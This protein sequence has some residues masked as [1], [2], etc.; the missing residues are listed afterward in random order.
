M[1]LNKSFKGA[2]FVMLIFLCTLFLF[3]STASAARLIVSPTTGAFEVG[4]TFSI[5]IFLDTEGESINAFDVKLNF[6]SGKLQLISPS[7]GKSIVEIWT[8]PPQYNNRAGTVRLQ[9]GIPNGITA[10]RGLITELTFRVKQVGSAVLIFS[11]SSQVLKNDGKA[12]P[13]LNDTTG[14]VYQLILPPPGGPIVASETHP[15]QSLWYSRSDVILRWSNQSN[16]SGYSY[17]LSNDPTDIPDNTSEGPKNSVTY[18]QISD[19]THYF[20]IKKLRGDVWGGVT[21]FAINVDTKPPA[22]FSVIISPSERTTSKNPILLFETTD[23]QS[24]IDYYEIKVVPLYV[25][26]D[27]YEGFFIESNT[28]EV[29]DL[30]LGKYNVIVRAYDKAGNIREST[31]GIRV[32]KPVFQVVRG[33]GLSIAGLFII[34][35]TV[36]FPL[37]LVIIGGLIYAALRIRTWHHEH[38]DR[39]GNQDNAHDTLKEKLEELKKRRDVY[40]KIIILLAF[41]VPLLIP[42]S[43][44]V[45]AQSSQNL[46]PPVIS[47]ISKNISNEDIFYVGGR[48]A[49]PGGEVILYMQNLQSGEVFSRIVPIEDGNEWFYRHDSFLTSGNYTLWTQQQLGEQISAPSPQTNMNVRTTAIQFGSSRL[50][51][52]IVYLMFS[53]LLFLTLVSLIGYI[54]FHAYHGRKWRK[55]FIKEVIEAEQALRQGFTTLRKDILAELAIVNQAK[56][57]GTLGEEE[58]KR[59]KQL[60]E[61]LEHIEKNIGKEIADIEQLDKD[62]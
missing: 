55:R 7:V 37:I 52:E 24:G 39:R 30:E 22:E 19:G 17:M 15:D 27:D 59:K 2:A 26:E 61:D 23:S 54:I 48:T 14:G 16:V 12:T 31:Q 32:V 44:R 60:L 6:P 40:T 38:R 45:F 1:T 57:E 62:L 41:F 47:T 21:H 10:N 53:I 18:T 58:E 51:L 56:L 46:P 29:L 42:S 8:G 25:V 34:P 50:S 28:R 3:P 33:R 4:S 43:D 36:G 5:Q 11:D 20:H 13:V 9:G 49:N 35:W